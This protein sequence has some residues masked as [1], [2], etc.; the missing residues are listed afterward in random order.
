VLKGNTLNVNIIHVNSY[1][2]SPNLYMHF[3][4]S[5]RKNINLNILVSINQKSKIDKL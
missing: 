2:T 3:E 5:L 4:N 1:Y